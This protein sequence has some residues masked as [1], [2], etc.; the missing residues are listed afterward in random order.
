LPDAEWSDP[1]EGELRDPFSISGPYHADRELVQLNVSPVENAPTLSGRFSVK[2]FVG[3]GSYTVHHANGRLYELS[4][5][6]LKLIDRTEGC[7]ADPNSVSEHFIQS[8]NMID[9]ARDQSAQSGE[10]SLGMAL[11][12][13]SGEA[14]FGGK[15]GLS[16]RA[17]ASASSAYE[18]TI[19]T[20]FER[21]RWR[22]VAGGW[23]IGERGGGDPMNDHGSLDGR[24]MHGEPWASYCFNPGISEAR[25]TFDLVLPSGM[26]EVRASGPK[27]VD[28]LMRAVTRQAL[29]DKNMI[30]ADLKS[31]VAGM[32]V[33]NEIESLRENL[34]HRTM[35][36]E[37]VVAH[38]AVSA[39]Q[40]GDSVPATVRTRLLTRAF[41]LDKPLPATHPAR[42]ERDTRSGPIKFSTDSSTDE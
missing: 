8:G 38:A 12:A 18:R 20:V 27:T 3:C 1:M 34:G 37:F 36:G 33:M 14:G 40:A 16:A 5:R 30:L 2:G 35:T 23:R 11:A 17:S 22:R 31:K 7:E 6:Q 42:A 26:L 4:V 29:A 21:A 10:G 28:G 13:S 9:R 39:R 25:V 41:K 15:L 24:Y 19:Q 32:V